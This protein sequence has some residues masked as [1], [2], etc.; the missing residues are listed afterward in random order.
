MVPALRSA[1]CSGRRCRLVRCGST[2]PNDGA[3]PLLVAN[4][5]SVSLAVGHPDQQDA[6]IDTNR[7]RWDI[8]QEG[9]KLA[10]TT[11]KS[12]EYHLSTLSSQNQFSAALQLSV[13]LCIERLVKMQKGAGRGMRHSGYSRRH[14]KRLRGRCI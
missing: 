1:G 12:P 13:T 10:P 3:H 14:A 6:V 11:S 5:R 4:G 7:K 9:A 2:C 8:S